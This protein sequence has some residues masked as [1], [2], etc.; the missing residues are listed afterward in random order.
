MRTYNNEDLKIKRLYFAGTETLTAGQPLCYQENPATSA[1]SKGFP[2]DVEVP[3]SS[4][5]GAFAGIVAESSVGVTGPAY[6]DVIIPRPGD[7]IQVKVSRAAD[8][9]V[10]TILKLNNDI[11]TT[12]AVQAAFDPLAAATV[13]TSVAG[14]DSA[15]IFK[16]L[17]A[18]VVPLESVA[19]TSTNGAV[20]LTWV[21]FL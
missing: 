15:A 5:R 7:V 12:S 8:V 6:I 2:F 16:E 1:Q 21:R 18:L 20:N 13:T 9:A 17:P 3:N 4:N 19:S 11:D 10:G 14:S